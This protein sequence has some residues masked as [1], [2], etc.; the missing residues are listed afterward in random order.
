VEEID[1]HVLNQWQLETVRS[2]VLC[3]NEITA[4]TIPAAVAPLMAS[5]V[6]SNGRLGSVRV[7][8]LR[9]RG[10]VVLVA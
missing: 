4:R 3:V 8:R 10:L 6:N 9:G 7:T 2:G 5:E 1:S